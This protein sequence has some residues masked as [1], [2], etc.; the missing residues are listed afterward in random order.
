M[1]L[2]L[3]LQRSVLLTYKFAGSSYSTVGDAIGAAATAPLFLRWK[4]D[5]GPQSFVGSTQKIP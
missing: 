2:D 1:L 3:L 4:Y 5:S